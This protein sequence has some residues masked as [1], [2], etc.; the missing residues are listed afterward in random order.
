[1]SKKHLP[2]SSLHKYPSSREKIARPL[3]VH[4]LKLNI[5]QLAPNNIHWHSTRGVTISKANLFMESEAGYNRHVSGRNGWEDVLE[6]T[7]L[8]I[9]QDLITSN[10]IFYKLY[11][12]FN[13]YTKTVKRNT[14]SLIVNGDLNV[15]T[16][17]QYEV[18][19]LTANSKR[20]NSGLKLGV[21][22]FYVMEMACFSNSSG[23]C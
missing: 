17:E 23:S 16:E 19:S 10:T 2:I 20:M 22:Q 7:N 14:R 12:I 1:M 11:T 15:S 4:M 21:L 8:Y 13:Q 9:K 3:T 5:K 6:H 18:Y